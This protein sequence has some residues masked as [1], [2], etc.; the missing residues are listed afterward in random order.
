MNQTNSLSPNEFI[1]FILFIIKG[2]KYNFFSINRDTFRLNLFVSAGML[3]TKFRFICIIPKSVTQT[4]PGD[5]FLNKTL[6]HVCFSVNFGKFLRKLCFIEYS[7][8]ESASDRTPSGEWF[9]HS[10]TASHYSIFFNVSKFYCMNKTRSSLIF[11]VI[12]IV[13]IIIIIIVI[14]ITIFIKK[15]LNLKRLWTFCTTF[16]EL[17]P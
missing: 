5:L 4:C 3:E 6:W 13:I 9:C 17:M 12:I 1:D 2:L 10:F 16:S 8:R 11:S 15:G 7:I 14:I